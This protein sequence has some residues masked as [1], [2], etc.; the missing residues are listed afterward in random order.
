MR[1]LDVVIMLHSHLPYVLNHGRWPHGSDWICE[2]AIDTYLPL[3]EKLRALDRENIAAPVTVG[4]TPILANQLAHPTFHSELEAYFDQRLSFCDEAP[5]SLQSTGDDHLIP[6]VDF[7]RSRLVRLR[8]LFHEIERDIPGEFRR[9]QDN[10]RLEITGSAATHGFLPLLGR[11][12]SIRLQLGLGMREH[13][14]VFGRDAI[15]CWLPEC[16]YRPRGSWSPRGAPSPRVRRGIEEHVAEAGFG[17]F[18]VDAHLARAGAPLGVYGEVVAGEAAAVERVPRSESIAQ[19][20]KRSPYQSYRVTSHRSPR[21]VAAL[22]RDPRSSMQVWSRDMGYPGSA[23]YLEFHKIRWPGGLKLWRVSAPRTDLGDK[24]PYE[25]MVARGQAHADAQHFTM[26]LD[27]LATNEG[28]QEGSVVVAPFDTEL[29]GHWWF[30]GPDFLGDVYATLP[31]FP[32]L[33]AV[34]GGAHLAAHSPRTGLRL[35]SGS[36]GKNGDYSMWFNDEVFW[37]WPVIWRLEDAFWDL[38]PRALE[39]EALHPMLAQAARELLLL[40]S[41][42][43]QFIIST[44]EVEDYAVRRFNG[45]ASDT[46][47]LIDALRSALDGGDVDAGLRL[48][49]E[50]QRR[51]DVFRDIIPAIR[52]AIELSAESGGRR[53]ARAAGTS[54]SASLLDPQASSLAVL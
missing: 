28:R 25:P 8:L 47:R 18:F 52:E 6:L 11:D 49:D 43:W 36:W 15:G 50:L 22:V 24:E 45:H 48:A 4:F 46:S 10:E 20:A 26:L 30:E 32:R 44:G 17:Y 40:Q 33:R 16:A 3:V 42:D 7:W 5:E 39:R 23:P 13:R 35:V 2:A 41:S 27:R 38:A 54:G 51:D 9:L 12:E 14:R 31:E 29:Y 21:E 19:R 37:T 1:Q 34:T 53:G